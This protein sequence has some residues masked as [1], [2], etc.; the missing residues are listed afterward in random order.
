MQRPNV[1]S[2][3]RKT[4]FATL[5][6]AKPPMVSGG[7]LKALSNYKH[8][9]GRGYCEDYRYAPDGTT[10]LPEWMAIA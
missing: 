6:V 1:A 10:D 8:I 2:M 3:H 9:W 5:T 4:R 7:K